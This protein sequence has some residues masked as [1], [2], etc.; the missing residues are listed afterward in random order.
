LSGFSLLALL[1]IGIGNLVAGVNNHHSGLVAP[2]CG[3]GKA[4]SSAAAR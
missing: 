2:D 3:R 4:G 1:A